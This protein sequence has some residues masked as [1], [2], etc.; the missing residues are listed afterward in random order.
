MASKSISREPPLV[1]NSIYLR[2]KEPNTR[3][4]DVKTRN[5]NDACG[6]IGVFDWPKNDAF[7]FNS[8]FAR[9]ITN[10]NFAWA[11]RAGFEITAKGGDADRST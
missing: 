10:T 7:T 2:T 1:L 9:E 3:G 4:F 5:F 8:V 11:I 6:A